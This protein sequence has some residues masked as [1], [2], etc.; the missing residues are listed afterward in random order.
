MRVVEARTD[1]ALEL[2]ARIKAQSAGDVQRAQGQ[3]QVRRTRVE[4]EHTPLHTLALTLGRA[5]TTLLQL[6]EPLHASRVSDP[7]R[8]PA[9]PRVPMHATRKTH[10]PPL[11]VRAPQN[12][13]DLSAGRGGGANKGGWGS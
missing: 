8:F 2:V 9:T 4:I 12:G 6:L 13:R 1:E 7:V 11:T 10:L 3:E 5:H